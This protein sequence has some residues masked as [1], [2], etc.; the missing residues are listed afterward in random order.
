MLPWAIWEGSVAVVQRVLLCGNGRLS[1]GDC[2][3]ILHG[4]DALSVGTSVLHV[5]S[6]QE[7]EL[8]KYGGSSS[9]RN[10]GTANCLTKYTASNTAIL[11][12]EGNKVEGCGLDSSGSEYSSVAA[13]STQSSEIPPS[14]KCHCF[15]AC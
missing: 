10:V 13:C 14:H 1:G 6:G 7:T 2:I 3:L 8:A 9:F 11:S 12:T 15:L 4:F 5:F